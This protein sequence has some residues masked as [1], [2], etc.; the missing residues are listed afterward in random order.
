MIHYE[1]EEKSQISG[2]WQQ[3]RYPI[4]EVGVLKFDDREEADRVRKLLLERA[5][6]LIPAENLRIVLIKTE[7]VAIQ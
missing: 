4:P 2:T 7:R 5:G 3:V 6:T 1:L